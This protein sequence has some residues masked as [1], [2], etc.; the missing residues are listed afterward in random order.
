LTELTI[1][2]L[3]KGLRVLKLITSAL[4]P[5]FSNFSA[6]SKQ[7]PTDLENETSVTSVPFFNIYIIFYF[8]LMFNIF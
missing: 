2:Y 3:S 4:I 1:V 7:Q 6:A 5:S 8:Y